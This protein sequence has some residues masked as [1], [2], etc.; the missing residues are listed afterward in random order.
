MVLHGLP[1][2]GLIFSHL[3]GPGRLLRET[4][5]TAACGLVA[6]VEEGVAGEEAE[7]VYGEAEERS[8]V[9]VPVVVV[10][11]WESRRCLCSFA[12][13]SKRAVQ[14]GAVQV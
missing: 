13:L 14:A 5:F 12:L 4:L 8:V 9:L 7:P 6:L 11:G 10:E 1:V 2:L 3:C